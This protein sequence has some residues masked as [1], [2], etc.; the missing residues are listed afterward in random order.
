MPS[1]AAS[2]IS[3]IASIGGALL[4]GKAAK[5]AADTQAQAADRAAAAQ[6]SMF[7]TIRGDLSPYR[8]FG[9]SGVNPLAYGL[10]LPGATNPGEQIGS[11]GGPGGLI[12]PFNPTEA[13]LESTPGYKFI[14]A[15]GLEATQNSFAAQGLGASGA[16]ARGASQYAEGLA[17]TFYQQQFDNYWKQNTTVANELSNVV[18][19]GQSASNQTGAFGT[20]AAQSASNFSTSGAA[21]TAAGDV[22]QANAL[23]GGL[24]GLSNAATLYALGQSGMFGTPKQPGV[25]GPVGGQNSLAA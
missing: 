25:T 8:T 16:A 4:G 10:G 21:A 12:A 1:I 18:G 11:A 5:S 14:K 20:S 2:A 17:S 13:Q 3:G 7:N 23:T 6:M 15:Q 19:T 9:A 24:T 22:G